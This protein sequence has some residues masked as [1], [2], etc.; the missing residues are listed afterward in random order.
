MESSAACERAR[1]RYRFSN[2][3][4]RRLRLTRLRSHLFKENLQYS[5]KRA[6]QHRRLLEWSSLL[7]KA[8]TESL[9][10][11][12]I[13]ER[14]SEPRE[15]SS[16]GLQAKIKERVLVVKVS[17]KRTT[18]FCQNKAVAHLDQ[19]AIWIWECCLRSERHVQT[20]I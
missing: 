17:H 6:S 20:L 12:Q 19:D 15:E 13:S 11:A 4:D 14:K 9:L 1:C 18:P 2:Q 7:G 8:S 16:V 10:L 5:L 3:L